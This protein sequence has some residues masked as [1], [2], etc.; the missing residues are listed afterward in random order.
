MWLIFM[1]GVNWV[2]N[3]WWDI[4]LGLWLNWDYFILGDIVFIIILIVVDLDDF[5][6]ILG[7]YF[8]LENNVIFDFKKD[9]LNFFEFRE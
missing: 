2:E 7:F 6:G 8:L 1:K 4:V 9:I 5:L 3:S